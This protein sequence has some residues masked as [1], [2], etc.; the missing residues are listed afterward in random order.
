[1]TSF[2]FTPMFDKPLTAKEVKHEENEQGISHANH[3][4][5]S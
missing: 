3:Q 2:K 5:S 1:L 4:G